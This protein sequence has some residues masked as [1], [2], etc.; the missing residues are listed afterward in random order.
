MTNWRSLGLGVALGA[1]YGCGGSEDL[2]AV[3]EPVRSPV[4]LIASPSPAG[5]YEPRCE[6]TSEKER[7]AAALLRMLS[8]S[9]ARNAQFALDSLVLIRAEALGFLLCELENETPMQVRRFYLLN[10]A[11]H[12][13]PVPELLAHREAATVGEAIGLVVGGPAKGGE[14]CGGTTRAERAACAAAW[15][16]YLRHS[17]SRS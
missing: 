8:S 10:Q 12:L 1:A 7:M 16:A 13:A 17:R 15:R 4:T 5:A 3:R 2:P 14:T 11:P 6:P 9:D